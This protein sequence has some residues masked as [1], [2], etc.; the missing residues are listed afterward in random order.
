MARN[1]IQTE[2]YAAKLLFQFR[3]RIGSSD[4]KRRLCEEQIVV[5]HANTASEALKKA[6][7]RGKEEEFSYLNNDNNKVYFE[8]IGILDLIHLGT[9]CREDEVWYQLKEYSEP[10]ERRHKLLPKEKK[11]SAITNEQL[12]LTRRSTGRGK[13]RRAG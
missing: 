6:K 3:V 1:K 12:Y 11:L 8:F 2:R 9:E 5:F 10:K 4:N 7:K 13:Q